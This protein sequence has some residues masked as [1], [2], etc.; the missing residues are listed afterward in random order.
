MRCRRLVHRREQL[1]TQNAMLQELDG[2]EH[3]TRT[4]AEPDCRDER[5]QRA[6]RGEFGLERGDARLYPFN[7]VELW[8][9]PRRDVGLRPVS[10]PAQ[11]QITL[12]F[13]HAPAL[14]PERL[15]QYRGTPVT[16]KLTV[17]AL[18]GELAGPFRF[19]ATVATS[20]GLHCRLPG[21]TAD[22]GCCRNH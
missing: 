6:Q 5:Q 22:C 14:R 13:P 20:T 18:L 12:G 21:Q 9:G 15:A 3:D 19:L 8:A 7:L 17:L 1:P 11:E 4:D 10:H 2:G 16:F